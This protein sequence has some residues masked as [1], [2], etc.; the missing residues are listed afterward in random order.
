[1][2]LK[3]QHWAIQH[4]PTAHNSTL[5]IQHSTFILSPRQELGPAATPFVVGVA[6]LAI[7]ADRKQP[8]NK[9]NT[10]LCNFLIFY[11][12]YNTPLL[13]VSPHFPRL[14]LRH[15]ADA[16]SLVFRR[17]L[18]ETIPNIYVRKF[19]VHCAFLEELDAEPFKLMPHAEV[20]TLRHYVL[21]EAVINILFVYFSTQKIME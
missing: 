2:F 14:A 21:L 20:L 5:N 18:I 12:V 4:A 10:W 19:K 16:P 7:L 15:T 17:D 6:L 9:K 11:R 8:K 13:N 1:M 3:I